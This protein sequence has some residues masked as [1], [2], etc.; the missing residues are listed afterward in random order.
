MS[1]VFFWVFPLLFF[2]SFNLEELSADNEQR[3]TLNQVKQDNKA[4]KETLFFIK[5]FHKTLKKKPDCLFISC[6]YMLKLNL[7]FYN[8]TS[9]MKSF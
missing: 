8:C 4:P 3:S 6:T 1:V 5:K 9:L 2:S 7:R